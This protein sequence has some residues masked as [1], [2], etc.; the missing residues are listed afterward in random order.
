MTINL[1]WTLGRADLQHA[2]T[3]AQWEA[4][5]LL[6]SWS[7]QSLFYEYLEMVLQ[8]GFVTIFVSAFPLAPLFAF[9]N[10]IL[11][12]RLDAHKMISAYRRPVAVRVKNIGI[13]YRI[14]DSIGRL[15]VVTNAI[16]IAF[17]SDLIPRIYFYIHYK[18]LDN[19]LDSTLAFFN[20]TSI[21]GKNMTQFLEGQ[22]LK[23]TSTEVCM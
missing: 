13:W 22:N 6:A 14:L 21:F 18:S 19:Y 7:P 5:Y 15:S 4:D 8:F 12:V 23:I 10:N 1:R 9:I 3:G 2:E 17:A 16:V 20:Q 11:E